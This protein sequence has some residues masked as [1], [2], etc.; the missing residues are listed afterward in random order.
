MLALADSAQTEREKKSRAEAIRDALLAENAAMDKRLALRLAEIQTEKE[1]ELKALREQLE[2]RRKLSERAAQDINGEE[3]LSA[4]A[5]AAK[6]QQINDQMAG[7]EESFQRYRV[8]LEKRAEEDILAAHKE[9]AE[10]MEKWERDKYEK[11]SGYIE[12]Y[13]GYV[14]SAASAVH[15][16]GRASYR[17]SLTSGSTPLTKRI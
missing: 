3:G 10:D 8:E 15:D 13:A 7:A 6:I 16:Y 4:E 14:Q 17:P 5:R 9:S 11:I 2:E 1:F 12:Q